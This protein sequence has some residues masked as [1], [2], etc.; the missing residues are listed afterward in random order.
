VDVDCTVRRS[1]AGA[2]RLV[3]HTELVFVRRG[4]FVTHLGSRSIVADA[5][6][7]LAVDGGSTVRF[8]HP[9]DDGDRYTGIELSPRLAR[10]L[11]AAYQPALR[12]RLR[13]PLP[14]THLPVTPEILFD[15][16]RLRRG[17]RRME[18]DALHREEMA[19]RLAERVVAVGYRV[20]GRF[21]APAPESRPA[22]R[23]LAERV[24]QVLAEQP[25]A[26]TSLTELA[27]RVGVSPFH[28]A[29]TFRQETGLP[30][31]RYRLRLRLAL[32][33]DRVAEGESNLSL[34]GFELGFSSHS[35]FTRQFRAV[36]GNPPARLRELL[37][38]ESAQ[39][40]G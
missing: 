2:E 32:A 37:A 27:A 35:H 18:T 30:I 12:D 8:S 25:A 16:Q 29:R 4:V 39:A 33:L 40:V 11:L 24:R 7:V 9:T 13:T 19:L 10:E 1:R 6:Q 36:Y 17:M 15:L 38:R 22:R 3:P 5:N 20:A 28:L 21:R 34:L 26:A 14:T 31:H 23:E